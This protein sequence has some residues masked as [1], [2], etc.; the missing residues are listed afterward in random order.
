LDQLNGHSK[1]ITVLISFLE[2][3]RDIHCVSYIGLTG[4]QALPYSVTVSAGLLP[5]SKQKMIGQE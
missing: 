5:I 1:H 4:T 3:S 2:G